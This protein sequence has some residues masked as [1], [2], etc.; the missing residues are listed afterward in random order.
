MVRTAEMHSPRA[1]MVEGV[2]GGG[3]RCSGEKSMWTMMV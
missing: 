3:A 1:W 2:T